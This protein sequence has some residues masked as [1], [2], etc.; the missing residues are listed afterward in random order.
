LPK[1]YPATEGQTC[2]FLDGYKHSGVDEGAAVQ[3]HI[4]AAMEQINAKLQN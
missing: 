1:E 4:D 3:Q 2:Y